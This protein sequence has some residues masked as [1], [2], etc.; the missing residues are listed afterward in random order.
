YRRGLSPSENKIIT[1][2]QLE[3]YG[4]VD[5]AL[6]SF[7]ESVIGRV[8]QAAHVKEGVLRRWFEQY[9]ITSAGTRGT[10]FRGQKETGNVPNAAVDELVNQ[11]I[12]RGEL[13]GG[14][15]WYELTHDRLIGPIKSSNERWFVTHSGGE[16]T[17][18]RLESRAKQ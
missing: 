9:L 17:P 2:E 12:I 11:H 1:R 13:R 7:Y 5:Q 6:S 16:Q 18:K 4:D 10:V 8:V 14:S 15:R 3:T